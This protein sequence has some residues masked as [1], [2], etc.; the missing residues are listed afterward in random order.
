MSTTPIDANTFNFLNFDEAGQEKACVVLQEHSDIAQISIQGNAND[1]L[2]VSTL[3][4]ILKLKCPVIPNRVSESSEFALLAVAPH[5]WLLIAQPGQEHRLLFQLRDGLGDQE[6]SI[7]DLTGGQTV[8]SIG[9]KHAADVLAKGTALDFGPDFFSPFR[10]ALSQMA[11]MSVLIRRGSL[12]NQFD[13]MVRRSGAG[14]L[15]MWLQE[16][17][18]EFAPLMLARELNF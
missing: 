15:W 13:I 6:C 17:A 9:G 10:C 7:S 12:D 14:Y 16:A 3:G 18:K 5:D 2:F 11:D 8:I 4:H 1:P